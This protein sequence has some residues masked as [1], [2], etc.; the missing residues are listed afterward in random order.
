MCVCMH[1]CMYRRT[2]ASSLPISQAP[3][4][5]SNKDFKEYSVNSRSHTWSGSNLAEDLDCESQRLDGCSVYL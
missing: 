4:N 2:L 1:M 5:F 3:S